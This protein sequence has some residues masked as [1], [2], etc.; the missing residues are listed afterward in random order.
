MPDTATQTGTAARAAQRPEFQVLADVSRYYAQTQPDKIA[1]WCGQRTVTYAE[2]DRQSDQ[3]AQGLI[4][5]GLQPGDR[6]AYLGKNSD[7]YFE[8]LLAAG[9]SGAVLVSLNWRLAAPELAAI[10]ADAGPRMLF[11]QPEFADLAAAAQH[12]A[13]TAIPLI[14][15]ED[16]VPEGTQSYSAWRDAQPAEA[17]AHRA[18]DSDVCVMLYTSGTTGKPKGVQLAHR[19]L[20][21]QSR[22]EPGLGDWAVWGPD[23]VSL[24]TLPTFHISGTAFGF[25]GLRHGAS[26]VI[27]PQFDLEAVI[28]A[29]PRY[30]V[31][32][33]IFVPAVIKM[34]LDHPKAAN[35]DF[36]SFKVINY[37][38]SPMPPSLLKRA[39]DVFQS[40]FCQMYG[41]TENS[42][43]ATFLPPDEHSIEG[44]EKM[45]GVG[46]PWPGFEIRIRSAD[47]EILP[48]RQVGEVEVRAPTVMA[49][50]WHMPEETAKVLHDDGFLATGDAGY[51]DEDGY[52]YLF[53]RVKDMIITG[54]ENVYPAEV[55]NCLVEH[56][57]VDEV[58]VIGV[59]D[60]KWG[61]AV[62]AIVVPVTGERP[63][64]DALIAFCKERIAGYKAP[65]R[66]EFVEALPRNASGK[67]L[68]RELRAPYWR[69]RDRAI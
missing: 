1:Y 51:M 25:T 50:Y 63:T 54:G 61:E 43:L 23:E 30:R 21:E 55:E 66:I 27:L 12:S 56:P 15:T 60:E 28:D 6:F 9:K 26:A 7:R 8:L 44:N 65:K 22:F 57:A 3:A 35:T 16:P 41:M 14:V 39:I 2:L 58:A 59:P 49:G 20:V 29:I 31:S 34:I 67:V 17:P 62:T 69:E 46:R 37:G 32:R 68:R 40:G 36:S 42:G 19:G 52:L 4:A 18:K 10:I 5:A 13:G 64:A 38:A 45:T 53:D 24:V 48:P 47:G 11:A 33:T